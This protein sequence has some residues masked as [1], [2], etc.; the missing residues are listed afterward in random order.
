MLRDKPLTWAMAVAL[1]LG[2]GF[3]IYL[4][5]PDPFQWADGNAYWAAAQRL[6]GGEP[7][8][9]S[10]DT[11]V[12]PYVYA[13]WFAWAW[14]PLTYL[15]RQFVVVTWTVTMLIC[16]VAA[17][18][19]AW[20]HPWGRVIVAYS[21]PLLIVNAVGGNVQPAV[22]AA[23]AW[24]PWSTGVAASLKP[25]AMGLLAIDLWHRR[26]VRVGTGIAVAVLLWAP[27]LL[28][29]LSGYPAPRGIAHYDPTLLLAAVPRLRSR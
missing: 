1:G 22:A 25:L 6:R 11:G 18:V 13:P 10:W 24:L 29:D 4:A 14:V 8:Y 26:W 3:A 17:C 15:P 20:R 9:V 23:L 19:P 7:L 16:A 28:H 5:G 12:Q 2:L 21:L 27:I